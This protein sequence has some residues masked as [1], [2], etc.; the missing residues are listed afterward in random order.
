MVNLLPEKIKMEN[1]DHLKNMNRNE[2]LFLHGTVRN[3][4]LIADGQTANQAEQDQVFSGL[5]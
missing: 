5:Y 3:A 1:G 2:W 4:L